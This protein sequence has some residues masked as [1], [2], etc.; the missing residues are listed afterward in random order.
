[1]VGR[2]MWKNRLDFQGD[3]RIQEF[4]FTDSLTDTSFTSSITAVFRN[5]IK[6]RN[7][8]YYATVAQEIVSETECVMAIQRYLRSFVQIVTKSFHVSYRSP[9]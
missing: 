3:I 9:L 1:M 8:I 4:C 6:I 7:F 2:G 5:I